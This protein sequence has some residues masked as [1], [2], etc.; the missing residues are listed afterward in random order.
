MQIIYFDC[1]SGISG[2]MILSALIDVGYP[3]EELINNIK[4]L[5]I[6]VKIESIQ[7]GRNHIFG[8]KLK[9]FPLQKEIKLRNFMDLKNMIEQSKLALKIKN[10]SIEILRKIGETEAKI[11]KVTLEKIQFHEI[12]ATDTLID[13]IGVILGINYLQIEKIYCSK[14]NIGTGLIKNSYGTL[15]IPAPATLELLKNIPV[16]STGIEEELATP[17]GAAII[18]TITSEF[19]NLPS[20]KIEKIGYGVG[21]KKI[22]EQPNLL[23]IILGKKIE[24]FIEDEIMVIETNIDDMSPIVYEYL[25]EALFQKNVLDVFLTP[26]IMKKTRPANKLTVLT[27]PINEN[28]IVSFLFKETSSIGVRTYKVKRKKISREI[29]TINTSLGKVKVKISKLDGVIYNISPEYEECKKIAEKKNMA[30][31]EVIEIIKKEL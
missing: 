27:D 29:K 9:I 20:I 4:L 18:S 16:Y 21:E 19:C 31:K 25:I 17:T 3:L 1:F 22:K 8:T 11:H 28:E 24:E 14:I 15:P 2:D 26:I 5:N 7:E 13:V 23:R 12:G 30:L 10:Q 6:N